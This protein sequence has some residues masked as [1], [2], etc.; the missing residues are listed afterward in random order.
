MFEVRMMLPR[1]YRAHRLKENRPSQIVQRQIPHFVDRHNFGC[2]VYVH[3]A[4]SL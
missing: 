2:Q 1:S 3:P 4:F